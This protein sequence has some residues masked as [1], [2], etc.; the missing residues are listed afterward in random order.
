MWANE[1]NYETGHVLHS[2]LASAF[3]DAQGGACLCIRHA[4]YSLAWT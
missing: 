3:V 4:C 2:N 1:G